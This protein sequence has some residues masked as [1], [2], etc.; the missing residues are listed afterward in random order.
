[1]SSPAGLLVLP[2]RA[3]GPCIRHYFRPHTEGLRSHALTLRAPS[4]ETVHDVRI[5]PTFCP[6]GH[7]F[8]SD[9][10]FDLSTGDTQLASRLIYDVAEAMHR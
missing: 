4:A 7:S 3:S 5:C 8:T 10:N 6:I 9:L 1:M 2:R